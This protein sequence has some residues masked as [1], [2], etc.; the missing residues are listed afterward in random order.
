MRIRFINSISSAVGSF[1]PNTIEDLDPEIANGF[2]AAGHAEVVEKE[3]RAVA[4]PVVEKATKG[5]K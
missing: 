2:V 5:R 3:E 4:A 1:A